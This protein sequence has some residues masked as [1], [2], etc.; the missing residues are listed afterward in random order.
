V[1][2]THVLGKEP[3]AAL[4][5]PLWQLP[6]LSQHPHNVLGGDT[7]SPVLSQHLPDGQEDT[8]WPFTRWLHRLVHWQVPFPSQVVPAGQPQTPLVQQR[9]GHWTRGTHFPVASWQRPAAAQVTQALALQI[10]PV[11]QAAHVPF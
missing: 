6:A 7:H 5:V 9:P 4:L 2:A 10:V 11:G 3:Q 8:H 1:Q